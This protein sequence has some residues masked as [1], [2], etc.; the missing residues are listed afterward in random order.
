MSSLARE[1]PCK[2]C[3]CLD[4]RLRA[5]V[6]GGAGVAPHGTLAERKSDLL[7]FPEREHV[8]VMRRQAPGAAGDRKGDRQLG[9]K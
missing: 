8:R 6:A 2:G 1:K 9:G 4:T 3:T 7:G 5:N